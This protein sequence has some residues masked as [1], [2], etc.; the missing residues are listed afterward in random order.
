VRLISRLLI[1]AALACAATA[2]AQA[3]VRMLSG[4]PPGGAV[5]TLARIF[6]D[7]LSEALGRP[8]VVENRTGAGGQIAASVLKASPADGTNL[9]TIPASALT[10]YPHTTKE[11]LNDTLVD[12]VPVAHVGSYETGLFVNANTPVKTLKEWVEWVKSDKKNAVYSAGNIATDLH[13]AGVALGQATGVA[14]THV[15]YRGSGPTTVALLAGEVPAVMQPYAQMLPHLRAG[16]IRL[17][18]HTG[19]TRADAVPDVPTF[20]ELGYPQLEISSWYVIIA[21][22]KMPA[23]IVARYN[24]IFN[25]ALRTPSVR[26]R[27]N[28]M[29][30]E[31]RE[32]SPPQL[33]ATLK[34]DYER[35]GPVVRAS[36]FT[37]TSQ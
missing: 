21:P 7:K 6:A 4:H 24:Q 23:E 36:G 19:A 25:S 32:L 3:P 30:L 22:A 35:W 5:D 16:K 34:S 12:F 17:I 14:L 20:K 26:E 18:A 37:T 10:L 13:F 27:M 11:P 15:P 9:Q 28:A 8:V 1:I 2:Q 29:S 33:V 31:I